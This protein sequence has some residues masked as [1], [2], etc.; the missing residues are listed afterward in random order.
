MDDEMPTL[1]AREGKRKNGTWHFMCPLHNPPWHWS[2][3]NSMVRSLATMKAHMDDQHPG[4][5]MRLRVEGDYTFFVTYTA[6]S[7]IVPR[8][9]FL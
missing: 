7:I 5:K 6:T 2:E 3:S 4:V 8:G 9:D 1:S